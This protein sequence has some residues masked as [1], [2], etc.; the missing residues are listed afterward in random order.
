MYIIYIICIVSFRDGA[1]EAMSKQEV[2][3]VKAHASLACSG[4]VPIPKLFV[5]IATERSTSVAM[6]TCEV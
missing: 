3:D 5:Y 6:F 1:T 4:F 2:M